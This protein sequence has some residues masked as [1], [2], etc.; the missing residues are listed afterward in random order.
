M[1]VSS[2]VVEAVVIMM[3][4][5]FVVMIGLDFVMNNFF[6]VVYFVDYMWNV[7]SDMHTEMEHRDIL[8]GTRKD[9]VGLPGSVSDSLHQ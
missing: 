7:H 3:T 4:M 1:L 6:L 9:S 8:L 2:E 5:I